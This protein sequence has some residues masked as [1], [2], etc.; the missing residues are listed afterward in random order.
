V[1]SFKERFERFRLSIPGV[2]SIDALLRYRAR[3]GLQRAD[4]LACDRR[5][6]IEVKSLDVS[7]DYK[8]Q[9]FL[10]GLA[11]AG[12]LPS[13]GNTT[14][15]ELLSKLSDGPALFDE[16]WERVTKVLDDATPDWAAPRRGPISRR[17][18]MGA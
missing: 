1:T 10:D 11:H 4:Y 13:A 17:R 15:A 8:I 5:V 14:L 6:V 12:H 18:S 9:R 16:A 7:P 3:T 2:E